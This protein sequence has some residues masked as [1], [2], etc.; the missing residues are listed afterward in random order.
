MDVWCQ[1]T[2]HQET[3]ERVAQMADDWRAL[4]TVIDRILFTISFL[5]LLGI[6]L[7]M[8]AKS[9][10]HPDIEGLGAVPAVFTNH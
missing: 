6:A 3:E 8:I 4:A 1:M 9:T 5:I 2:E 10:E 7:W